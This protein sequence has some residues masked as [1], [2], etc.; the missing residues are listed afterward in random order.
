[1]SHMPEE[2]NVRQNP[3]NGWYASIVISN[4]SLS[5][6][7]LVDMTTGVGYTDMEGSTVNMTLGSNAPC[8]ETYICLEDTKAPST[9]ELGIPQTPAEGLGA[10]VKET[11]QHDCMVKGWI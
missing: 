8:P 9:T 4:A 7:Q 6:K 11:L 2:E 5:E 10:V 1:M 3:T